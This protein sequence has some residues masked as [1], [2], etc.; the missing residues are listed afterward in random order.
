MDE[1]WIIPRVEDKKLPCVDHQLAS[2]SLFN[3][4]VLISHSLLLGYVRLYVMAF[5]S[6]QCALILNTRSPPWLPS[7]HRGSLLPVPPQRCLSLHPI[8][9]LAHSFRFHCFVSHFSIFSHP[10]LPLRCF[11]LSFT[12]QQHFVYLLVICPFTAGWTGA[13]V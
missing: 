3:V 6:I 9:L 2:C 8:L 11:Y 7:D 10:T 12:I 5:T 1:Y 4:Y 13:W